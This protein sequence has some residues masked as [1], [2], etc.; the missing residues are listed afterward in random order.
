M[1]AVTTASVVY[2]NDEDC[3]NIKLLSAYA[4]LQQH[5]NLS[6]GKVLALESSDGTVQ[7]TGLNTICR[8]LAG[9]SSIASQLLGKD[10]ILKAQVLRYLH[11]FEI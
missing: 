11:G 7:L 6:S 4:N 9:L 10:Q 3:R 8:Y 1:V 2:S 5:V